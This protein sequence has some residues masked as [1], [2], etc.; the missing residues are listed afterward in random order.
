MCLATQQIPPTHSKTDM[1][2][3]DMSSQ[4]NAQKMDHSMSV[5]ASKQTDVGLHKKMT[6]LQHGAHR[7]DRT[8][9]VALPGEI[10]ERPRRRSAGLE[11]IFLLRCPAAVG[12]DDRARH[13]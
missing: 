4:P 6:K 8:G 2:G 12:D 9:I 1:L 11:V 10:Q 5:L 7:P 13:V 3:M